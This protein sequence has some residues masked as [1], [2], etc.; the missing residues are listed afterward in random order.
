MNNKDVGAHY[1]F[2]LSVKVTEEDLNR[3]YAVV[4]IDPYK[5]ADVYGIT[6]HA[7]FSALKK[8]LVTG[9]RGYKDAAQD[10][11]DSIGA[12]QRWQELQEEQATLA[13]M[14]GK[15]LKSQE[16]ISE[17]NSTDFAARLN[18]IRDKLPVTTEEKRNLR[19]DTALQEALK[20]KRLH[21]YE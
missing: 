12:L 3:G 1:R 20:I 8:L 4:N 6:N 2:Q 13:K 18:R 7:I 19:E 17:F 14:V 15:S 10:V 9:G 16:N 21:D 5:I 11:A